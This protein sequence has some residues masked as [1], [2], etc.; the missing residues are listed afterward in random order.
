MKVLA[1]SLTVLVLGLVY[2]SCPEKVKEKKQV[3][4]V[5]GECREKFPH[6]SKLCRSIAYRQLN[7]VLSKNN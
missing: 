3:I 1:S 2:L 7:Q 6:K 4:I 5:P